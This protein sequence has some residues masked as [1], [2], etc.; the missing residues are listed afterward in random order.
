ME[1][2]E[3]EI[4]EKLNK[5]TMHEEDRERHT[6]DWKKHKDLKNLDLEGEC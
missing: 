4:K 2:E 5:R 3:K 1:D 6:L